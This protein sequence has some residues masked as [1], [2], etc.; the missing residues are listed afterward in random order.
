MRLAR[1]ADPFVLVGVLLGVGCDSQS[2]ATVCVT[3]IP[4]VTDHDCHKGEHCNTAV[5]PPT[6]QLLY[7]GATGTACSED[8]LCVLGDGCGGGKCFA[9]AVSGGDDA[10]SDP[11]K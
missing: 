10:A 5:R 1:A 2:A 3:A 11:G 4:C 7:C 9:R 8:A 6:C